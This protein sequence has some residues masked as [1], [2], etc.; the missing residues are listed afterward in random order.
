M[1][2][3]AVKAR[4]TD[5]I[6]TDTSTAVCDG[7]VIVRVDATPPTA[8]ASC[9]LPADDSYQTIKNTINY[10]LKMFYP[11][12]VLP[13]THCTQAAERAEN[14]VVCPWCP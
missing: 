10:G 8:A 1:E 4:R 7:P 13:N 14:A 5:A 12:D 3:R 9:S 6:S 2:K 11:K